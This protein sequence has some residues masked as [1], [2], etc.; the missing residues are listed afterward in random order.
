MFIVK[1]RKLFYTL[2]ILFFVGSILSVSIFG[3]HLGIDFKG[4]SLLEIEYTGVRPDQGILTSTLNK[5]SL[6]EYSIRSTGEKGY[7]VRM[8]EI[9]P[10]EKVVIEKALTLNQSAPLTEARF[11]SIGPILGRE[12]QQKSAISIILVLLAIVAFI[13]FVFRKVSEPVSSWK[14]GVVAVVA[15]LHDVFIP[16][17]IFALLGHLYGY[18]IDTLFVTALLVILGFSVHDTIVVFDRTRENLKLNREMAKKEPF[19][20]TVGKSL[21]Q[22][23]TRSVNTSL[24]T[25][26]S[27]V[28]LYFFGGESTHAFALALIVGIIT[29]TYSSIFIASPLLVTLQKWQKN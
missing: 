8:R 4:G 29:G 3:L 24:V 11:N 13:A 27:L 1:N 19:E 5:L 23:F 20:E 17:G 25:I 12:A 2:S 18:E 9:T 16:K 22:T 15:L 28:A 14:Y 10:A 7:I 21:R 26:L 6:G